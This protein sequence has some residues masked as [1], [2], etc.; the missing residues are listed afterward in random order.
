MHIPRPNAQLN[1]LIDGALNAF[2]EIKFLKGTSATFLFCLVREE[3]RIN[4][5]GISPKQSLNSAKAS[6]S[7]VL[8]YVTKEL[9]R[10]IESASLFHALQDRVDVLGIFIRVACN[11]LFSYDLSAVRISLGRFFP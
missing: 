4:V 5:L 2:Y 1:L 11:A 10:S 6:D 9:M 8:S 3:H 7:T